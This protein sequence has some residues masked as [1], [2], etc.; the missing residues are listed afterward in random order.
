MGPISGKFTLNE[1]LRIFIPGVY[2]VSFFNLVFQSIPFLNFKDANTVLLGSI[3]SILIGS[4]IYAFDVP[5][6]LFF[7]KKRLPTFLL[8]QQH[9]EIKKSKIHNQFFKFYDTYSVEARFKLELYVG[10][11][12][13]MVNLAVASLF[14]NSLF[15]FQ[16]VNTVLVYGN[17]GITIIALVSTQVLYWKKIKFAFER[18][19]D[20]FYDST[21]YK[22]LLDA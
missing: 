19:L 4:L 18:Q 14:C 13:L 3:M 6:S 10:L 20:A 9:P 22:T 16:S 8:Q 17:M 2:T 11:Y 7:Y 12:H 15:L 5:R 1:I 21:Q